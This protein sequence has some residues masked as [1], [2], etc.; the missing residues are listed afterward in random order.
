MYL[1]THANTKQ[2]TCTQYIITQCI[3]A[4]LQNRYHTLVFNFNVC[5]AFILLTQR[6]ASGTSCS[7]VQYLACAWPVVCGRQHQE[8]QSLDQ[9]WPD[10][11]LCHDET[12]WTL[13]Y[14]E[15][16]KIIKMLVP[17][18]QLFFKFLV[19]SDKSI[20]NLFNAHL[21]L[22]CKCQEAEMVSK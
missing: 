20:S 10:A 22:W 9:I 7:C 5:T 16:R 18:A 12:Y 19:S 11:A 21:H 6:K 8:G 14:L 3:T 17:R 15:E 2:H 1:D 13:P 4:T